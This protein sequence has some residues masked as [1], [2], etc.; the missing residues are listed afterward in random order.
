M[1][2]RNRA[3]TLILL[4]A[5]AGFA[6]GALAVGISD[7][8]VGVVLAYLAAICVVVAVAHSWRSS[9]QFGRL[10]VAS[11]IGFVAFAA[12]HIPFE[13][14]AGETGGL[15]NDLLGA[16]GATFFLIATVLCPAGLVVGAAGVVV[17][18]MRS[19]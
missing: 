9:R 19:R 10:M 7:N 17:S 6:A 1:T 12:L 11:I 5:G 14:L 8:A 3:R 13:N 2:P 15:G 4:G 16:L 18:R